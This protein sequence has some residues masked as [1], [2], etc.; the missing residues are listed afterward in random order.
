[1]DG[2]SYFL[3]SVMMRAMFF[4]MRTIQRSDVRDECPGKNN[5]Q[6]GPGDHVR[7]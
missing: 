6:R 1:M 4:S 5:E 2:C 3:V 7:E